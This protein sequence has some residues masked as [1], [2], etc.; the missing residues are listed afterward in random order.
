MGGGPFAFL[1]LIISRYTLILSTGQSESSSASNSTMRN[2]VLSTVKVSRD[3]PEG[4]L[5]TQFRGIKIQLQRSFTQEWRNLRRMS[6]I[7]LT[8]S[9][10]PCINEHLHHVCMFLLHSNV[11]RS[12]FVGSL[13]I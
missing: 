3:A 10:C 1:D 12:A 11:Q 5:K 4:I 9:V 2:K 8:L 13:V 6:G 7:V